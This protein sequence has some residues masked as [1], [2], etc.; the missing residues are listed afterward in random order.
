[1]YQYRKEGT[2]TW[3]T[4]KAVQG[5]G[6]KGQNSDSQWTVRRHPYN[7]QYSWSADRREKYKTCHASQRKPPAMGKSLIPA[8]DCILRGAESLWWEW[9]QGSSLIFW[10]WP[11]SHRAWAMEGQHH[12]IIGDL[13]TFKKPQKRAKFPEHMERMKEKVMKVWW[14]LYIE[15]GEVCSL[16]H[17]FCVPKGLHD[18]RM[19][20]NG[21]ACGL[22]A[23]MWA[24]HFGLPIMQHNSLY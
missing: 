1:M 9:S 10:R 3:F 19:V 2:K 8:R 6:I 21:T 17:M 16:M 5:I 18:I 13:S 24:P 7:V 15:T 23:V 4:S 11:P 12:F 22:N 20:Y 14:R